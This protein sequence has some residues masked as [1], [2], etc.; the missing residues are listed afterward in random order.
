MMN[1]MVMAS[2][3]KCDMIGDRTRSSE[4]AIERHA[5]WLQRV[6]L[7]VWWPVQVPALLSYRHVGSHRPAGGGSASFLSHLP[8]QGPN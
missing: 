1:L 8:V 3:G 4:K 2:T 6:H 5:S 7:W